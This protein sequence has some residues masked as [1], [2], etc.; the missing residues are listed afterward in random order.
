MNRTVML[1]GHTVTQ[2][3]RGVGKDQEVITNHMS[4]CDS[5]NI[6]SEFNWLCTIVHFQSLPTFTLAFSF[7]L[8]CSVRA[9][10][11]LPLQIILKFGKCKGR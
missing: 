1:G 11:I 3:S 2:V 10:K 9:E 5:G 8:N 7:Q 6:A 4:L